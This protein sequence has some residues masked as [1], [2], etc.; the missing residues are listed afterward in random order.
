MRPA[1]QRL[2]GDHPARLEI[3]QRLV[4]ERQRIGRDRGLELGL[5]PL[6]VAIGGVHLVVEQLR[7]AL[8]VALGLV[9]RQVGLGHQPVEVLARCRA[10]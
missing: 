10:R 9:E 2:A 4:D 3:D 1:R 8:A 5:E 6:A 7:L